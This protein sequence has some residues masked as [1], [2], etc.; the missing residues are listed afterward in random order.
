[1]Y[2]G[3]NIHYSPFDSKP[4]CSFS[5]KICKQRR[6]NGYAF[7]VR[8]ILEDPTAPW[9]QCCHCTHS[10]QKCTNA[11]PK[12]EERIYCNNHRQML[13]MIPKRERRPKRDRDKEHDHAS[14]ADG[15]KG[16]SLHDRL[17]TKFN[18]TQRDERANTNSSTI[19]DDPY[20][21]P[22]EPAPPPTKVIISTPTPPIITEMMA[23]SPVAVRSP[24]A[25]GNKSPVSARSP[26]GIN[27]QTS[28][29]GGK[30]PSGINRQNNLPGGKS[31]GGINRQ[32][33]LPG[34]KSPSGFNRQTSV[35]G[36]KSP[37]G[38]TWHTVSVPVSKS[39]L[40]STWQI[41]VPGSRSPS[42][43]NKQN[44]V[45]GGKGPGAIRCQQTSV[46]GGKSP[47]P[48]RPPE[49][50]SAAK[51]YPELA[52]KLHVERSKSRLESKSKFGPRS[53]RTVNQLETK[54][55]QN[56]MKKKKNQ[57]GGHHGDMENHSAS[58][59]PKIQPSMFSPQPR[60]NSLQFPLDSNAHSSVFNQMRQ[61]SS[62]AGFLSHPPSY[63]SATTNS[64]H[65]PVSRV[66][67]HPHPYLHTYPTA[68]RAPA[69]KKEPKPD[70]V[71]DFQLPAYSQLDPKQNFT[72]VHLRKPRKVLPEKKARVKLKRDSPV[73]VYGYYAKR[74]LYN[75]D[76]VP[77]GLDSSD[78]DDDSDIDALPWQ[79]VW[80][81]PSSD[82]EMD[83]DD[84]HENSLPIKRTTRLALMR[85]RLRR[86][87]V[88]LRRNLN[89]NASL[90]HYHRKISETLLDAVRESPSSAVAALLAM[91]EREETVPPE[92]VKRKVT[93]KRGCLHKTDDG[94]TCPRPALPF[95]N[96][97]RK[98][99][100]YNVDQQMF[101][102]CTARCPETN[103]QCC[104]PVF[105]IR[106]DFPL[107][108]D[109]AAK[110]DYE[111]S[112]E[113]YMKLKKPRKKTKPS[114]LTRPPKRG[115]K[116]KNQKKLRPQKPMPPFGLM[117]DV[118]MPTSEGEQ[119]VDIESSENM[120]EDMGV[121]SPEIPS[122]PSL[123]PTSQATTMSSSTSR[124]I[125]P[126]VE[127]I[128]RDLAK[129]DHL[130]LTNDLPP[131][132]LD[133]PYTSKMTERLDLE[134]ATKLLEDHDI[135][136]VLNKLPDEAF[137]IF[138][139][140]N[141][142][143]NIPTH[144]ETEELERALAAV[145]ETVNRTKESLGKMGLI[146]EQ[147]DD[148]ELAKHI[149]DTILN[150]HLHQDHL[151]TFGDDNLHDLAN[152]ISENDL[153][154]MSQVLTSSALSSALNVGVEE[155]MHSVSP[156]STMSAV[157]QQSVAL[158]LDHTQIQGLIQ[159]Q[160]HTTQGQVQG[161]FAQGQVVQIPGQLNTAYGIIMNGSY[162]AA[163][164]QNY[165]ALI[166]ASYQVPTSAPPSGL[167]RTYTP[168]VTLA[169]TNL[170]HNSLP[171]TLNPDV[172][173]SQ[174]HATV[175]RLASPMHMHSS[176]VTTPSPLHSP[177]P[178]P[179]NPWTTVDRLPATTFQNGYPVQF[180]HASTIA[181]GGPK[182]TLNLPQVVQ[183]G[184]IVRTTSVTSQRPPFDSRTTDAIFQVAVTLPMTQPYAVN[185]T[186]AQ[187]PPSS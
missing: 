52:E 1:M 72:K 179:R 172:L 50:V 88:Q 30:S 47:V 130:A 162:G 187:V 115:K 44:S 79:R 28:L 66:P 123:L 80:F 164:V 171:L 2:E 169:P 101:D 146:E 165:P 97:C 161:Q 105:D 93:D 127:K 110:A 73:E 107:C 131:S 36:A 113:S 33:S 129:L 122:P 68:P 5:A 94:K 10:K 58:S 121:D 54:I 185:S 133:I 89:T 17:K 124:P 85:A 138:T 114:A 109:H 91:K 32:N 77:N 45:P 184:D 23:P 39:P 174:M 120:T 119:D 106:H 151:G 147:S 96:Q 63:S 15:N 75:S 183:H 74:Q 99:I 170:M 157:T 142:E 65:M 117:G 12:D 34:G 87:L 150:Q 136:E 25:I 61:L 42:G 84:S 166:Q 64:S 102:Y 60:I 152:S 116:K 22:D 67:L 76:L 83:S 132:M 13:G 158:A 112:Q 31:P 9:K 27:R 86:R 163:T 7:C 11:I 92:R 20:A 29:P 149:A 125:N 128:A 71:T 4:L 59:S 108:A 140:K 186:T 55:A 153:K 182:L 53:S 57:E 24:A 104:D 81:T 118:D 78:S 167:P 111:A 177:I 43:T 160:I 16:M 181:N 144:E 6:L 98:H 159:S 100:M 62:S 26:G 56:K 41:S 139:G 168:N 70:G 135:N 38:M 49:H 178:N 21:F 145:S 143:Y 8:H 173:T 18:I 103:A 51:L 3:K 154:T 176:P 40:E 46:P 175:E 35:P 134:Q 156:P 95:A 141:G 148:D 69:I 155:K 180:T 126:A 90:Q 37:V 14:I 137:D 19:S 48:G 82:E